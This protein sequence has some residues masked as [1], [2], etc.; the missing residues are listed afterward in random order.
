MLIWHCYSESDSPSWR[1]KHL[2]PS[3]IIFYIT[4]A[5]KALAVKLGI[6]VKEYSRKLTQE[7]IK[8][9]EEEAKQS[10]ISLW[11]QQWRYRCKRKMIFI[12]KRWKR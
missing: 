1:V 12:W 8:T 9:L 11:Q 2:T 3:R 7:K 6:S 5:Q 10:G 4:D